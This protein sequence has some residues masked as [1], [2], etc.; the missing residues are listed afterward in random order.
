MGVFAAVIAHM[1]HYFFLTS[2]LSK[3]QNPQ[4]IPSGRKE[5]R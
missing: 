5:T 4:T 2:K 3:F 1:R